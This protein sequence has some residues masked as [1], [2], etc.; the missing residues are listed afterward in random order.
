MFCER[1]MGE[2]EERGLERMIPDSDLTAPFLNSNTQEGEVGKQSGLL[3]G[4]WEGEGGAI[5]G[6][7][8]SYFEKLL[9][10]SLSFSPSLLPSFLFLSFLSPSQ[11]CQIVMSSATN[12][13]RRSH[14][15]HTVGWGGMG[16]G[17][18]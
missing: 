8:K 12:G 14:H 16:W 2:R 3:K 10:F 11:L 4:F 9:F 7:K 15:L 6:I 1:K 13:T 18:G 5:F 17:E